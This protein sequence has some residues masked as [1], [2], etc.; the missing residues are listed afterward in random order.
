[1]TAQKKPTQMGRLKSKLNLSN[2]PT[3][4]IPY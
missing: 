2:K 1:M 4:T 3:L